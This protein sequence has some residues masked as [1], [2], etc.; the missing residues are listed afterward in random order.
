VPVCLNPA[1]RAYLPDIKSALAPL[2]AE[3][4]GAPGAPVRAAQVP[5]A[6]NGGSG[7]GG[8]P[9]AMTLS[10]QPPVLHMSLGQL[11]LPGACGFCGGPVAARP[12]ANQ[13]RL[14]VTHAL[15]GA[16][17]SIG[18]P[19][20]QAVLAALLR[21]AGIPFAAQ[22]RLITA[23]ANLE[24]PGVKPGPATGPVYAAAGRLAARPA[25]ARRAWFA[26]HLAA[27]QAGRLSLK[28]LP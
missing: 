22:P 23:T 24:A 16:R 1:Y 17:N 25:S 8:G 28:E 26:A 12:F 13:L 6:Y 19:A 27:L 14:M 5:A 3:V 11:N 20:Q 18:N 21:V 10:G 7:P 2:L 9:L 4:A 15:V